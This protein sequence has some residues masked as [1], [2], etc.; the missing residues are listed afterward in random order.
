MKKQ[1]EDYENTSLQLSKIPLGNTPHKHRTKKTTTSKQTN[2]LKIIDLHCQVIK[3]YEFSGRF[4]YRG[5]YTM[6][7]R[8]EFYVRVARN[9]EILL[10][11][12]GHK[13]HIFEL[14]CNVLFIFIDILIMA[15]VMIFRRF[16]TTF[17]RFPKIL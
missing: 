12:S 13:I 5:C 2:K 3:L 9:I 10:L 1:F 16:L 6:E 8:Y 14:T 17:R 4:I 7:R 15:F 11:P